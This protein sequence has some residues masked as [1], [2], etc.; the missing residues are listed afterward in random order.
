MC[1]LLIKKILVMNMLGCVN[2]GMDFFLTCMFPH[3][4][5]SGGGKKFIRVMAN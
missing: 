1:L 2:E 3:P 5:K 4:D